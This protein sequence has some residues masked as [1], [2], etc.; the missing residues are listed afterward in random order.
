MTRCG[1]Q[2][3][4]GTGERCSA[5]HEIKYFLEG[6]MSLNMTSNVLYITK[7]PDDTV[8]YDAF[9]LRVLTGKALDG[10]VAGN[11]LMFMRTLIQGGAKKII[12]DM[13]RLEFIDSSGISVL[14]ET[15]KQLRSRKGDIALLNVP[16]RIQILFQPI[17][18]NRF[19]QMF[20]TEDE[21]V[22]FFKM[23]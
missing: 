19:I 10:H 5:L 22:S 20:N 9:I 8:D 15:A 13:A 16:E 12:V 4:G 17:K 11:M 1:G 23:V 3:K 14:I 2:G 21:A 7:R 6:D 18:L